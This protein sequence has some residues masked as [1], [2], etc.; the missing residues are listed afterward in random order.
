[1]F[2]LRDDIPSP[3]FPFIVVLLMAAN[4]AVYWF[5]L[6]LGLQARESFLE[7]YALIPAREFLILRDQGDWFAAI[8]PFF[9][10][11]FLHGGFFHVA[12]NL[13][14]LWIFGDNV[15]GRMGPIRFLLF[16]LFCGLIAGATHAY[17][18]PGSTIPVVGASG[19]ISG[20][21]GAYLFLFP[22][23]RLH[24]FALLIFYPIFF[25][26]PAVVFLIIW[27]V[28]QLMSGTVDLAAQAAAGQD[29]GGIA[30]FAHIGG[31]LGG[32]LLLPFFKGPFS[33]GPLGKT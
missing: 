6:Q 29:V 22:R 30:F 23:A 13:W 24:M 7:Q 1:M 16:Y 33:K 26:I 14:S 19:A 12:A 11:Q 5:E 21:M 10:S 4:L 17:L 25:E 20:V 3:R 27:F 9:T 32:V 28:G 2:P 31:F 8:R 18:N 15:E